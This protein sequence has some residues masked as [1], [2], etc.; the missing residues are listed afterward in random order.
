M[1]ARLAPETSPVIIAIVIRCRE[2]VVSLGVLVMAPPGDDACT[3][4]VQLLASMSGQ[5][6][7]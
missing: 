2:V 7:G 3:S 4:R 1:I 5:G 6:S